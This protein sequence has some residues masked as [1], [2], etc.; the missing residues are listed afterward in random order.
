[1]EMSRLA[2]NLFPFASHTKEDSSRPQVGSVWRPAGGLTGGINRP[3]GKT[4]KRRAR[5]RPAA[6]IIAPGPL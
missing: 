3:R 5:S 1:M 6:S 4:N 2:A